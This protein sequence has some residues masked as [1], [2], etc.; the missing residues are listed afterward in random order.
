MQEDAVSR[1]MNGSEVAIIGMAGRFPGADSIEKLWENLAA[2]VESIW[3]FTEE[4]L[5]A[6]GLP[7]ERIAR[8]E[9]VPAA[10]II[11][12]VEVFDA[13]LFDVPPH[14][15][16]IMDP[17][18]R[19]FL[20][21]AWEALERAGYDSQRYDG[22]IGLFAG[23][24]MNT[25]L[26]NLFSDS[27]VIE[28][29]GAFQFE[30]GNDKD[31]LATRVSYKLDLRGPSL[32]V[33]S[34]CSTSLEAVHLACQ[35]LLSGECDMAL[36]GGIS[37]KLPVKSGYMAYEGGI[38]SPDG[39]CRAFDA[40]AQGTVFGSGVALVVLKRLI[41]ALADGDQVHAVIK[42]S[43]VNN[44]GALK[45]G[46][47]APGGEGQY[48]VVRAAQLVAEVD[49]E[50]ITYIETH[51]TGTAMGD[52][53]EVAALTRAFRAS[54]ER[55][56]FCAIGSVKTNVGHLRSAAGVTGLIKTVLSM[57]HR[58]LPPSLHFERPNPH[59]D[60][61]NSPFFVN[62]RLRE[63]KAGGVPLRAGVSSFGVGGTNAHVIVEEAPPREPSPAPVRPWQLLV[64]SARTATALAA[65]RTRLAEHLRRHP[66]L[67]LADI[68]WTLQSGRRLLRHRGTL[69]CRSSEEAAAALET[70]DPECFPTARQ[71]SH[72]RPVVFLFPGQG[73]QHPGMARETY[74][75]EPTFRAAV[76]R[77]CEILRPHLGLDLHEVLYPRPGQEE[78]A[79]PRLEQTALA[80]PALFVIEHSLAGLWMEW[81]V[82]P[83]AML[84]HSLG[85]YVAACQAGVFSL[86][87][88]LVLVAERGRLMQSLP[89]GAMLSVP[90]PP[91]EVE[92]LLGSSLSLAAVNGPGRSVVSGPLEAVEALAAELEGRSIACRLLHT[93][94]AFHSPMME[95]IL[96]PFAARVAAVRRRPPELPFVSNLTGTWI[97]AEQATDPGYWSRHLRGT[98]RFGDG[99]RTLSAAPEA[100]L[101]EVGPGRALASF[102]R[103]SP[104]RP[105]GQ[106][107][108]RSLP[109]PTEA[110]P[111]DRFLASAVGRLWLAGVEIDWKGFQAGAAR[112]RVELPG[113]PFERQRYWVERRYGTLTDGVRPEM[114]QEISDWFYLLSWKPSIP[115]EAEAGPSRW[116]LLGDGGGLA[117]TMA[118]R[119]REQGHTVT[120]AGRLREPAGDTDRIVHLRCLGEAGPDGEEI[121]YDLLGLVQELGRLPGRAELRVVTCG[122]QTVGREAVLAPDQA[123]ALGPIRVLPL[124]HPNLGCAAVDVEAPR[125]DASRERLAEILIAEARA[126]ADAPV[127]AW[128]GEE[129]WVERLDPVRL[130]AADPARLPLR[131]RGVYLI[132]GGLGGI[133][134]TLARELARSFRARLVLTGRALR[135]PGH[136]AHTALRELEELEAEVLVLAADVTDETA[137]R[138]V[139]RRARERFG[140]I[141]GAIHAAGVPGGGV[142]QLKTAE[143]ASRV[144]APK[145][146]GARVLAQVLA[147]EPLDVLVFCSS[148]Y[149]LT[150]GVG[151]VD[152]CAANS[153]LD[154]FARHLAAERG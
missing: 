129:R 9:Y 36:A 84:G 37:L 24:E 16:R 104:D 93:S 109:H 22:L 138:E 46:Y 106:A 78:D 97:T 141:Q 74:E 29:A 152:Y 150:G 111:D 82:R 101:L 88:A 64:L 3:F 14:E 50:T 28:N 12:G 48:Q 142:I 68:A 55:K 54:T 10:P 117:E 70:G 81:G 125:D 128:R 20:E 127:V 69:V 4:E 80:Q 148:T 25:Y 79:A 123:T 146:R 131:E 136:P 90:L 56:G 13:A 11:E 75:N 153:F 133:G 108:V 76:D 1:E 39:H 118:R 33:Q 45:V 102:A 113:Y 44:D 42:G 2:G 121:F 85:E 77:C 115:P 86:E 38:Q 107:L 83:R 134:L 130:P 61:A 57:R 53:I 62:D 40:H 19:L 17:Q 96:A 26:Y 151:Q 65:A 100:L 119:L 103:Q 6:A 149:A 99:L 63:W 7:R 71:D 137:M 114:R 144:M 8:P 135:A 18:H 132:T 105:A 73:S 60:F 139:V 43:A 89:A 23:Q 51:G 52:P 110:E 35:A 147:D 124:E 140:P 30:I 58:Q 41:D 15:A 49:A 67:P 91:V 59:I 98:V 154:A 94:H 95:P 27:A 126:P 120:L 66:E 34:A 143:V 32:T 112:Q 21:A 122:L 5:V 116:L 72:N 31:Y 47:S 145:V 87:D 92:P